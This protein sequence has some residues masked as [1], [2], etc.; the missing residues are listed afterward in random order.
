MFKFKLKRRKLLAVFDKYA[1]A[2][3]NYKGKDIP[4]K[5]IRKLLNNLEIVCRNHKCVCNPDFTSLG[6]RDILKGEIVDYLKVGNYKDA[7]GD[8]H[9]YIYDQSY[10]YRSLAL[11]DSIETANRVNEFNDKY[12]AK[13]II[14]MEDKDIVLEIIHLFRYYLKIN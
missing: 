13:G 6:R 1:K 2:V 14:C 5:N 8:F 9:E 11:Y 3:I 12:A 7:L 10:C 4:V